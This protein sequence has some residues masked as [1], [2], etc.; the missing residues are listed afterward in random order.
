VLDPKTYVDDPRC[1]FPFVIEEL[2]DLDIM[3]NRMFGCLAIYKGPKICLILRAHKEERAD[4]GIW[5]ATTK[6]HHQSLRQEIPSLRD[7]A[8]FGPGPTG[9]QV[10]PEESETFEEEVMR[11][12]DLVR[13]DDPRVGK[14]PKPKPMR[15]KTTNGA[16]KP[17]RKRATRR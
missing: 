2:M 5:I 12:C 16:G 7:I 6:E 10:I 3:L 17:K 8:V 14:I 13:R 11:A 1:P 9:W 4:N 15:K